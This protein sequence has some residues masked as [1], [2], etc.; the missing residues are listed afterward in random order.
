MAMVSVGQLLKLKRKVPAE[1]LNLP[2]PALNA[3]LMNADKSA[4][5][6]DN[7]QRD[8]HTASASLG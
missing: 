1:S 5:N 6:H 7:N 3:G 2:M 4:A 8:T